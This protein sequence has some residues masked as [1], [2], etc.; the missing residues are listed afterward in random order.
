VR[1]NGP[2]K[3]PAEA[4]DEIFLSPRVVD[5]TAF[6]R[7]AGVLRQLAADAAAKADAL[8]VAA[9]NAQHTLELVKEAEGRIAGQVAHLADRMDAFDRRMAAAEADLHAAREA[10]QRAASLQDDLDRRGHQA[11]EQL[12]QRLQD[13]AEAVAARLRGDEDDAAARTRQAREELV[14][15]L[16]A[17]RS[18]LE[19][20]PGALNRQVGILREQIDAGINE[21]ETRIERLWTL[22]RAMS[23]PDLRVL[24]TLCDRAT[25]LL[26]RDPGSP[27]D[28]PASG[29][30]G[31][32]VAR[33]ETVRVEAELADRRL[34]TIRQQAESARE[35][36]GG[37]VLAA[38]KRVEALEVKS[39][40]IG[41]A[42][43]TAVAR[44]DE[45][46]T[47]AQVALEQAAVC[48]ARI[49]STLERLDAPGTATTAD[50]ENLAA[51][52]ARAV[53]G[54]LAKAAESARQPSPPSAPPS[55]RSPPMPSTTVRP[56]RAP[57]AGSRRVA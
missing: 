2:P 4:P 30:L 28:A 29:S 50:G 20:L 1:K 12:A 16:G 11:A 7:Y 54:E 31:D 5:Q 53:S 38:E 24:S 52:I 45:T 32:L 48:L 46:V 40:Q 37:S 43:A 15:E 17:W 34:A 14:A 25:A 36:V 8:A 6:E 39:A 33:A 22:I 57:K 9:S 56:A 49:E 35:A 13:I 47:R 19:Q 3:P 27:S 23:G 26:G 42:V 18:D 44:G 41:R 55:P 10:G 51:A 21:A